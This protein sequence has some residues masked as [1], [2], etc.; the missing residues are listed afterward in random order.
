MPKSIREEICKGKQIEFSCYFLLFI[1]VRGQRIPV[2]YLNI[3]R[4]KISPR[5]NRNFVLHFFFPFSVFFQ[6]F[7]QS[8]LQPDI[9]VF[10]S[11]LE[12]LEALNTNRSLYKLVSICVSCDLISSTHSSFIPLER[13]LFALRLNLSISSSHSI[14]AKSVWDKHRRRG[15][16]G[17]RRDSEFVTRKIF[18]NPRL[19]VCR[20]EQRCAA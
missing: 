15:V 1:S 18:L 4:S 17:K 3:C 8:F 11:N 13:S 14:I 10:R 19:S 6:A 2:L 20:S 9:E 16:M 12:A 7:G 5:K